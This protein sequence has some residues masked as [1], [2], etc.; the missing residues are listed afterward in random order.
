ML[1]ILKLYLLTYEATSLAINQILSSPRSLRA[2]FWVLHLLGDEGE[3]TS[4]LRRSWLNLPLGGELDVKDLDTAFRCLLATGLLTFEGEKILVDSELQGV[5]SETGEAQDEILLS[6]LLQ[7]TRPL[8]LT[9]STSREGDLTLEYVPDNV[10]STL[11]YVLGDPARRESFLLSR[12]NLADD[13]NQRELG[14]L[15][16]E[17]VVQELIL[18]LCRIGAS[19]KASNVR[20]LSIISDELG[21]DIVAPRL[22][23][24]VRRIEVKTTSRF[25]GQFSFYIS[26]NEFQTGM[27]DPDWSLVF[28]RA[29]SENELRI[30]GWLRAGDLATLVPLDQHRDGSWKSARISVKNEWLQAGLPPASESVG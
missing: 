15:G 21:Y 1:A 3:Y 28:V 8:W 10:R 13:H 18:D 5:C 22:G 7:V 4:T 23:S 6:A 19:H 30:A 20:R 25:S 27:A 24:G 29:L 2:A 12:A 11:E 17:Y 26:R 14:A 9:V 16:E